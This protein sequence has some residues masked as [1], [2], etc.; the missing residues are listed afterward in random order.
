MALESPSRLVFALTPWRPVCGYLNGRKP[1]RE[2][3]LWS[4]WS[5]AAFVL[6][7][8]RFSSHLCGARRARWP[9]PFYIYLLCYLRLTGRSH[10]SGRARGG[11]FKGISTIFDGDIERLVTSMIRNRVKIIMCAGGE[12]I[13]DPAL[14]FPIDLCFE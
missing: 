4:L 7:A 11:L 6:S 13:T 5:S 3:H 12:K 14:R 8:V 2:R 9:P 10:V 1:A